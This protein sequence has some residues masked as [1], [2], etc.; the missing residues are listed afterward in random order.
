MTQQMQMAPYC[1]LHLHAYLELEKRNNVLL[2]FPACQGVNHI[3]LL[4]AE[5]YR[6]HEI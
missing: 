4:R 6:L 2:L 5:E 1:M 3:Q